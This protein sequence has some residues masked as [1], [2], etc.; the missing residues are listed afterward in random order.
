MLF[1]SSEAAIRLLGAVSS[2]AITNTIP[3]GPSTNV[4]K[5]QWTSR[6]EWAAPE[7]FPMKTLTEWT[8]FPTLPEKVDR[9]ISESDTNPPIAPPAV[10]PPTDRQRY[11][12]D[13]A[14]EGLFM[15]KPEFLKLI[16]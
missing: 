6:G 11:S 4:R 16:E 14:L 10:L 12:V 9:L 8:N 15:P 1:M 7:K 13:D 3:P 2:Q 5:V